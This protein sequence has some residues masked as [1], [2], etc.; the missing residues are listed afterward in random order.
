MKNL[1]TTTVILATLII[2]AVYI[3]KSTA[4][5]P[6]NEPAAESKPEVQKADDIFLIIGE[7][8]PPFEYYKNGELTG[9]DIEVFEII[10]KNLNVKYQLKLYPWSRAKMMAENGEADAV[11]SVSYKKSREEY[12][13]YTESQKEFGRSGKWPDE[14]LW[15]SEYVFFCKN[16]FADKIKFESYEQI[17]KDGYRVGLVRDYSY[18]P[19]FRESGLGS[20]TA[21]D[22]TTGFKLLAQ[23]KYDIFPADKTIGR[24]A[25]AQLDLAEKITFIP[26]PMFKKPYLMPFCKKSA[27]KN[28]EELMKKFYMELNNLRKSGKYVEISAKYFKN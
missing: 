2:I 22:I 8:W 5:S 27:W 25:L 24:A 1:L 26:Q 19:E 15:N 12:F 6:A 21:N 18:N 4:K 23:G 17:K 9:I 7:E 11:V 14:Y 3:S 16:I 28:K 20:Y 10:F 13:L